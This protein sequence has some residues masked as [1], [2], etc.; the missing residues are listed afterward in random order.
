[1]RR[2]CGTWLSQAVGLEE[3]ADAPTPLSTNDI[4]Q[5]RTIQTLSAADWQLWSIPHRPQDIVTEPGPHHN[6]AMTEAEAMRLPRDI[7]MEAVVD[8]L[9]R[10]DCG[11]PL[12]S[13]DAC[14]SFKEGTSAGQNTCWNS[15]VVVPLL[16][17]HYYIQ[18]NSSNGL[19]T[20]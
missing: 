19:R 3:V 14:P 16:I 15:F 2:G 7:H 8:T 20:H 12:G 10:T 6:R 13:N 9:F 1:M 5:S 18:L 11:S 17:S 4:K